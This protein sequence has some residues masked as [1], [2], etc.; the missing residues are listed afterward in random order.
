M[1]GGLPSVLEGGGCPT[2]PLMRSNT[3]YHKQLVIHRAACQTL[4]MD[5]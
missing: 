3:L 4:A 5:R 2:G 1:A